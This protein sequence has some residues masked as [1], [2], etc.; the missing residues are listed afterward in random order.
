M[1]PRVAATVSIIIAMGLFARNR[2]PAAVVALAAFCFIG[3]SSMPQVVAGFG[4]PVMV[5]VAAPLTIAVG[6]EMAGVSARAGQLLIRRTG[7][8][9]RGARMDRQP[10]TGSVALLPMFASFPLTRLARWPARAWSG[11]P[12]CCAWSPAL[13]CRW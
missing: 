2:L 10:E 4:D 5:L 1:T 9:L 7:A 12:D 3:V 11:G 13:R 6:L 8:S